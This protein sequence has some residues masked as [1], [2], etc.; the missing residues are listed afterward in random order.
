VDELVS[1]LCAKP[2]YALLAVKQ[3]VAEAAEEMLAGRGRTGEADIL[4][5]AARDAGGRRAAADYMA[6]YRRARGSE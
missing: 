5:E 3:S 2:R 1:T 4:A 6:R